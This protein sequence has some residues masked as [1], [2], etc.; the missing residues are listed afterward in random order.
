MAKKLF[1]AKPTHRSWPLKQGS[2]GDISQLKEDLEQKI[3]W[4]VRAGFTTAEFVATPISLSLSTISLQSLN[5][6]WMFLIWCA[7][8]P[9]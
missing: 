2:M 8:S 9:K 1:Y 3:T 5:S 4:G 7:I 6:I